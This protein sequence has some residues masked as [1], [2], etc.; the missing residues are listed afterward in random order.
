MNQLNILPIGKTTVFYLAGS[1]IALVRTGTIAKDS[2]FHT[3]LNSISTEYITLD[4]NDK[5]TSV[6]Q[7]KN[8]ILSHELKSE[9]SIITFQEHVN[10][11]LN[12][13]YTFI[14]SGKETG[15]IIQVDNIETYKLITEMIPIETFEQNILPEAYKTTH[16]R[17]G[18]R[19]DIGTFKQTIISLSID[20]YH[21]QFEQFEDLNQQQINFYINKLEKLLQDLLNEAD[22]LTQLETTEILKENPIPLIENTIN[23]HIHIIDS[24]I[25]KLSDPEPPTVGHP[26]KSIIIMS[27]NKHYEVVGK[28]KSGNR[29]QREFD[30]TDIKLLFTL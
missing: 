30:P 24:T 22:D 9:Q 6:E 5:I 25:R 23:R 4:F 13:F 11:L 21:K 1:K 10:I 2:L 27:H 3:I 16:L 28:L 17:S 7:F 15:K 12:N 14:L 18:A 19:K 20:Y 26:T 8:Y 29:I